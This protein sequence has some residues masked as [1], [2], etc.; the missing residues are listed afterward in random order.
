M[1][2]LGLH[3]PAKEEEPVE[4]EELPEE[5]EEDEDELELDLALLLPSRDRERLDFRSCF[6]GVG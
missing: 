5:F 3:R 4:L 6:C 2:R 1:I